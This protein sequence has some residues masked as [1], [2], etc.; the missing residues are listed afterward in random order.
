MYLQVT[1]EGNMNKGK[2]KQDI[3]GYTESITGNKTLLV[4]KILFKSRQLG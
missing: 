2:S 1:L 3:R 4:V